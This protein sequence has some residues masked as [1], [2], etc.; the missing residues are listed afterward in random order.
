MSERAMM[1]I[2][3]TLELV[4][5]RGV[6]SPEFIVARLIALGGHLR[7]WQPETMAS[8]AKA[9]FNFDTHADRDTFRARLHA[10]TGVRIV[11]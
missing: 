10:W 9:T 5:G 1:P 2:E 7:S 8:L 3:L 4:S 11:R 6:D